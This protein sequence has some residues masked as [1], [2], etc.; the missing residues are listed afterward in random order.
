MTNEKE[1]CVLYLDHTPM[2]GG[3]GFFC[4][5]C[6]LRFSPHDNAVQAGRMS[7]VME[8]ASHKFKTYN[9]QVNLMD[10]NVHLSTI[11]SLVVLDWKELKEYL[12][13]FA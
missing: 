12:D 11:R 6:M 9:A 13:T 5:K 4:S 10:G 1:K 7:A 2:W 8:I 3:D